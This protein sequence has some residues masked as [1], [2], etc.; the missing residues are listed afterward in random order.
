MWLRQR[1]FN[2][3]RKHKAKFNYE[4]AGFGAALDEGAV[5]VGKIRLSCVTHF[6]L[7][8]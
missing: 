8:E 2:T 4:M 1:H 5:T 6:Q 7:V 3:H